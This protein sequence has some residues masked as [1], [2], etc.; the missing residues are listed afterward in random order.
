[1][2]EVNAIL[3]HNS[4][5]AESKGQVQHVQLI[6]SGLRDAVEKVLILLHDMLH[7]MLHICYMT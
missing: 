3:L 1:M 2:H 4:R 5:L 6:L 7:N